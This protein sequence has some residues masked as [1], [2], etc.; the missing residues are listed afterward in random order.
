MMVIP[1]EVAPRDMTDAQK[2]RLL[3]DW[4]DVYDARTPTYEWPLE[5]G[6]DVQECLRRIADQLENKP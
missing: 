4:F 5:P 3:A 1:D 6:D 2:L